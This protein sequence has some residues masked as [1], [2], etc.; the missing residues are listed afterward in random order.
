M[1]DD[2]VRSGHALEW[3]NDPRRRPETVQHNVA[4]ARCPLNGQ[5]LPIVYLLCIGRQ[6]LL[7]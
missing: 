7:Q 3:A 6:L 2:D 4:N 5:Q 1:I